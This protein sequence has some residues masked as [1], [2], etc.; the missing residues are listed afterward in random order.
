MNILAAK[1]IVVCTVTWFDVNQYKH[2]EQRTGTVLREGKR[3]YQERIYVDFGSNVPF[4]PQ[5]Q[6]VDENDCLYTKLP[7][8]KRD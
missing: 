7:E 5:V 1:L 4:S 8:V 3:G 6:W 2:V